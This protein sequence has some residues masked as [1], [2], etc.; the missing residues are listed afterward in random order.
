[1]HP[2]AYLKTI[3]FAQFLTCLPNKQSFNFTAHFSALRLKKFQ[4]ETHPRAINQTFARL[5]KRVPPL[6]G[7]EK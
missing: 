3:E 5:P 4:Y 6:L 1:V 2:A 7:R